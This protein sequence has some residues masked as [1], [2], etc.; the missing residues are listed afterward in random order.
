MIVVVFECGSGVW[1]RWSAL[2]MEVW[3]RRQG[4]FTWESDKKGIL[5]ILEVHQAKNGYTK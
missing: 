3:E 4:F 1:W 2:V 5:G